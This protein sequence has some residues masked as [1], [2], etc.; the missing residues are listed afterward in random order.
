MTPRNAITNRFRLSCASAV[1][2]NAAYH[3]EGYAH[4]YLYKKRDEGGLGPSVGRP[5]SPRIRPGRWNPLGRLKIIRFRSNFILLWPDYASLD[6][7]HR[8]FAMLCSEISITFTVREATIS[9]RRVDDP[10]G[11]NCRALFGRSYAKKRVQPARLDEEKD[12][13]RRTLR[14]AGVS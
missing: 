6:R 3:L 1:I 5:E 13:G 12:I 4:I 2:F 7:A 8:S 10:V 9:S 11:R 14:V